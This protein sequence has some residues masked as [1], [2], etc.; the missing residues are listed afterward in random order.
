MT[1]SKNMY[2]NTTL[3]TVS[4]VVGRVHRKDSPVAWVVAS[5]TDFVVDN[6]DTVVAVAVGIAGTVAVVLEAHPDRTVEYRCSQEPWHW[7]APLSLGNRTGYWAVAQR[8]FVR[9]H[10]AAAFV[11]EVVEGIRR[12]HHK[13]AASVVVVVGVVL[14]VVAE[15]QRERR[16]SC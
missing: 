10:P 6:Q 5:R 13:A 4:T 8:D 7:N 14:L 11:A 16:P 3:R 2:K 15:V 12:E 9:T 1:R